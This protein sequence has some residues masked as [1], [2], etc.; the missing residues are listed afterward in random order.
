MVQR[1][2]RMHSGAYM[3]FGSDPFLLTQD[4]SKT[5]RRAF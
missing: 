4:S 3:E 2:G 1:W 5:V